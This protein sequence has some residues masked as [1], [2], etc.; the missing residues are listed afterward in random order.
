[1]LVVV[2]LAVGPARAGNWPTPAAGAS[3]SGGPE[4][5]FT[6]DDGP[7]PRTTGKILDTLAAHH[8]QAVF[9]QLGEHYTHEAPTRERALIQRMVAEGHIIA[10]H[11]VTHAQLCA[12]KPEATAWQIDRARAILE[13]E[14]KMPVPWFR[15]PYGAWCPRVFTMLQ[16]RGIHHFYWD[17]DPQEWRTGD[18]KKTQWIVQWGLKRLEGRAVVLMHDIKWATVFALPKILEWLDAENARRAAAG[19][20][21]IRVVSGADYAAELLGPDRVAAARELADEALSGL[22]AGLASALP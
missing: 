7:N 3:T 16:E 21:T 9:F 17:I 12:G 6:F 13:Q 22:A 20:Q 15:T 10:N 1:M 8:I 19:E 14:A 2:A 18:A 4:V 11:S 5:I